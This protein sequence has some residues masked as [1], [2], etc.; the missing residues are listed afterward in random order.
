MTVQLLSAIADLGPANEGGGPAGRGMSSNAL[1]GN[2]LAVP[3]FA[4]SNF[5]DS[6]PITNLGCK[7]SVPGV[8]LVS[9]LFEASLLGD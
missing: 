1:I 5:V 4:A 3:L 9:L 7:D 6:F 8:S 2:L